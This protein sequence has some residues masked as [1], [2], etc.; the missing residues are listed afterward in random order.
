[1]V[2]ALLK[3]FKICITVKVERVVATLSIREQCEQGFPGAQL[4]F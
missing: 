2:Q 1:M 3:H 4:R